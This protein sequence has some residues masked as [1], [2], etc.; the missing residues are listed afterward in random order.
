MKSY[1]GS[2]AVKG[3][4]ELMKTKKGQNIIKARFY[5]P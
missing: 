3:V 4:E 2:R 1:A 5:V